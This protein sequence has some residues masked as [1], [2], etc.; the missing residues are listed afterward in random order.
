MLLIFGRLEVKE[1]LIYNQ[2]MHNLY[3]LFDKFIN[4]YKKLADNLIN[5]FCNILRKEVVSRFPISK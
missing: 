3:A 4:K 5:E 1:L 2:A